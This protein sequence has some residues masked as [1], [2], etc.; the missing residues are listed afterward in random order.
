MATV[1][2]GPPVTT[3]PAG[4]KPT[5][6]DR[7]YSLDVFRGFTMIWMFSMAFGLHHVKDRSLFG[8]L[9]LSG[10]EQQFTHADWHGVF[11]WD[12]IQPF[13]MFIVGVAMPFSMSKRR[14]QGQSGWVEFRHVLWRCFLLLL[15]GTTARSISAGRPNLD[16]I[17][18]LGQLS[19]TYLAAY[20]VLDR[21]WKIQATAAAGLLAAHWAL[22]MFLTAPD[23]TGPYDENANI[24]WWLDGVVF[25]KHWGG[26]YATINCISSAANTIFG[27]M[28]GFWLK[29]QTSSAA[30]IKRLL[31]LGAVGIAAGL[32]LDPV[33]PLIKKTWTASFAI[34][35]TG[36][37]LWA[38]ALFYWIYDVKQWR[39]WSMPM[40]V[41]GMNSI[42]IYLFHEILHTGM[43]NTGKAV[44]FKWAVD[45]WGAWGLALNECAVVAFQIYICYWLYQRRIFFKI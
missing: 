9:P 33:I 39:R 31:I 23:V 17:N 43:R 20:L 2:E 6:T 37:T 19:F 28:A 1:A 10:I 18:V 44:F 41:V 5:A 40:A 15:L 34:F 30:K 25:G 7:L 12:M 22:Y 3:P 24:G 38:L 35:S 21:G 13:F 32:A 8:I 14:T 4:A 26:G 42:F 27:V 29:S 11:A 16:V 36:I 45:W